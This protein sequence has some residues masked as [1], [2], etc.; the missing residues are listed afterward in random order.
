MGGRGEGE[1]HLIIITSRSQYSRAAYDPRCLLLPP[2]F[3]STSTATLATRF[4]DHD[5]T[6]LEVRLLPATVRGGHIILCSVGV[7]ICIG[8]GRARETALE[9]I[10]SLL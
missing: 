3:V 5:S 2:N 9:C 7:A 8:L 6:H 1:V 4:H 10:S